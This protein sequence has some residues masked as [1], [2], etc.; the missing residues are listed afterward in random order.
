MVFMEEF[1]NCEILGGMLKWINVFKSLVQKYLIN[2][3]NY[4]NT[5]HVYSQIVIFVIF[6]MVVIF[7][8]VVYISFDLYE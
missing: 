1:L 8:N 5:F 7:F 3:F 4:L 2:C 6:V